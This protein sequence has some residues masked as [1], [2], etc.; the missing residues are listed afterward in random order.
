ME[1][2]GI[3][4]GQ[5]ATI[6]AAV[7]HER[8]SGNVV[9]GWSDWP[10]VLNAAGTRFRGRVIVKSSKGAGARRSWSGRRMPAACWHVFRD[11]FRSAFAVYPGAKFNTSLARY[12]ASNFESTYPETGVQNI[13]S[14]MSPVTMPE[15]CACADSDNGGWE[16]VLIR[17]PD[18]NW[19][20]PDPYV[21]RLDAALNVKAGECAW[22]ARPTMGAVA[23]WCSQGCQENWQAKYPLGL[24][25]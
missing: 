9:P 16:P 14:M 17:R 20:P 4:P 13:G 5:M 25:V 2:S 22:C 24:T 23:V 11:V 1:I 6:V 21:V 8:Y 3:T 12:T 18:T 19:Q 10:N 7:S 15:L